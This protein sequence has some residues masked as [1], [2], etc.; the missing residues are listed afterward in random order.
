LET[1]AEPTL[2]DEYW[3]ILDFEKLKYCFE[4]GI[5]TGSCPMAEL[6]P[7]IYNPRVLIQEAIDRLASREKPVFSAR[8]KRLQLLWVSATE[9]ERLV[10]K[11]KEMQA[12]V[13]SVA[14]E[15]IEKRK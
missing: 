3:K 12:I 8:R 1:A 11:I 2:L 14:P 10:S 15:E 4:C 7:E 13:Q 6:L 9:G 5:C